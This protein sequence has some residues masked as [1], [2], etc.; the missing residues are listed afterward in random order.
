MFPTSLR[1]G[2]R[3]APHPRLLMA[4]TAGRAAREARLVCASQPPGTTPTRSTSRPRSCAAVLTTKRRVVETASGTGSRP[5]K[6]AKRGEKG[7]RAHRRVKELPSSELRAR[8]GLQT[9]CE[10]LTVRSTSH[11]DYETCY[12]EFQLWCAR[13]RLPPPAENDK[14]EIALLDFLDTLLAAKRPLGDAQKVVAAV[15]HRFP[16]FSGKGRSLQPRVQKALA[17]YKKVRPPPSRLPLPEETLAGILCA[18]LAMVGSQSLALRIATLF[19]NYLRPG[20]SDNLTVADLRPPV[21]GSNPGLHHWT[22]N[23]ADFDWG[24][25][26]KTQTYDDAVICDHPAWLG[27]ALGRLAAGAAPT[28]PLFAD[29]HDRLLEVWNLVTRRLHLPATVLYQCRHG[30]ASEDTLARRRT[31]LEVLSRGRWQAVTSVRR[32]AKAA[33]VQKYLD[34]VPAPT[35]HY[36]QWALANLAL[37]MTNKI[38]ARAPP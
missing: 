13:Y 16:K 29:S 37:I 19:Y 10:S 25:P 3:A 22:L 35:R 9:R 17:G 6:N 24:K 7:S 1:E 33:Q 20:E 34:M 32:Y 5:R 4:G 31:P 26:S 14:L 12:E 11:Y 38:R 21:F 36:C 2:S 30:G 8:A 23:L 15:R 28:Q 27:P 18:I